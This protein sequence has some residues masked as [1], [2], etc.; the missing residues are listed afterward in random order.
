MTNASEI[1]IL[2]GLKTV[3][4][5]QD[6]EDK[7][8]VSSKFKKLTDLRREIVP[9]LIKK[10]IITVISMPRNNSDFLKLLKSINIDD[11]FTELIKDD[12]DMYEGIPLLDGSFLSA[13]AILLLEENCVYKELQERILRIKSMIQEKRLPSEQ[14]EKVRLFFNAETT[15]IKNEDLITAMITKGIDSSLINEIRNLFYIQ[16][17]HHGKISLCPICGRVWEGNHFEKNQL[18]KQ[19]SVELRKE[20]PIVKEFNESD[21]VFE[22]NESTIKYT[23]IPN[24][25]EELLRDKLQ[26]AY[27]TST[28]E[29][30][31]NFDEYDLLLKLNGKEIALDVKDYSDP[32]VLAEHFINSKHAVNKL[33]KLGYGNAYIVVMNYR[34][35]LRPNYIKTLKEKLSRKVPGLEKFIISEDDLISALSEI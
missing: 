34:A 22:L 29:M 19:L 35:N 13:D 32:K 21:V 31:P 10:G 12:E 17:S 33:M 25:G 16:S 5:E 11:I 9:I 23:L 15:M 27:P 8:E 2:D 18:C 30:Y 4:G 24:I 7:N 14:Y 26:A 20:K 3:F 1:K 6:H 28:V